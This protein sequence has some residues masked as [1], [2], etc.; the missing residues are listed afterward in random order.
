MPHEEDIYVLLVDRRGDVLW[1]A[2]GA[3]ASEKGE[4]L[5]VTVETIGDEVA[6]AEAER[7]V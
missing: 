2:E 3:F 4:S 1:R 6:H 5:A 7:V